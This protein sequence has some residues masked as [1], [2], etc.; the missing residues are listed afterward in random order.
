MTLQISYIS[1]GKR[2][3]L[4]ILDAR[5]EHGYPNSC[6]DL[7]KFYLFMPYA[8]SDLS[9]NFWANSEIPKATKMLWLRELLEGL[10]TLHATGN[11]HRDIRPQN[12]L[13]LSNEPPRASICDYGKVIEAENST[14]TTIGPIHSLAPEVWTVNIDGPYTAKVDTW[15]YGYAIAEILGYSVQKY[16]GPDGFHTNNPRITRNRH[17]AIL[18][19]L[20]AHCDKTTEDA[21]L[22][23]LIFKLL[24]WKPEQRWSAGQA[25]EHHCWNSITQ[26]EK[27]NSTEEGPFRSK[28]TPLKDL[29]SKQNS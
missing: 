25:L 6:C 10:G 3:L 13:I 15:A 23:D 28:K 9:Q 17:S 18:Q 7:E 8:L 12:M 22:V 5:C 19:M 21:P 4:P 26:E 24:I 2:G 27:K 1:Q 11:M 29:S 14:V 16:P 20:R